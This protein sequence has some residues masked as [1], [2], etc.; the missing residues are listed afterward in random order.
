[1]VKVSRSASCRE[2]SPHQRAPGPYP[3]VTM[4]LVHITRRRWR[5]AT[6]HGFISGTGESIAS[7][8]LS[9]VPTPLWGPGPYQEKGSRET[10]CLFSCIEESP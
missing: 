6:H 9:G 2:F 7:G 5:L 4:V 1:M 3:W 8:I 10:G